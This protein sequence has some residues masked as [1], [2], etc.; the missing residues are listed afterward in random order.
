MDTP[1]LN[2][3]RLEVAKAVIKDFIDNAKTD[4]L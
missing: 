2:P 1:D 3:S 4:R